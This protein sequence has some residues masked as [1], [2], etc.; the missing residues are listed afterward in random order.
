M[1]LADRQ[2]LAAFIA[3]TIDEHFVQIPPQ[4]ARGIV[5]D[6]EELDRAGSG[7]RRLTTEPEAVACGARNQDAQDFSHCWLAPRAWKARQSGA[8]MPGSDGFPRSEN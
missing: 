3:V 4:L 6:V 2:Y 7:A 8:Y 1:R 5:R